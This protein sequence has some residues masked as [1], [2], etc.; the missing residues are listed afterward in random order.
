MTRA[1]VSTKDEVRQANRLL[2]DS[3]AS[4]YEDIDGRRSP[5]L[6]SWLSGM[7]RRLRGAAPGP[8][9]LDVGA[10]SG[11]VCRQA[12]GIFHTRLAL[13][14]SPGILAA[15]RQ[16]FELGVA[17]D[18]DAL[19]VQNASADALV[20]FAALHHLYDFEGLA[21]EAAR[22]LKPGGVFYSD[23]DMD[24]SFH[25]RFAVPLAGY[26]RLR[27]AG[28]KYVG[29]LPGVTRRIYELSE[30]QEDGVDA[31]ALAA[32]LESLGFQ[33]TLA[34]HWYGLTP[35]TD[36]VFGARTFARGWAPLLRVWAVRR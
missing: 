29:A 12:Q 18:V 16:N 10:G 36:R 31:E 28:S 25:N 14:I 11:L 6:R 33:V 4:S 17:A 20:C 19:P 23:H 2:Y 21:R 35:V 32:L 27:D 13:D 7:L 34:R 3:A 30:W 24:K 9:L 15:H 8:V 1:A 22:V 5:A 26:R